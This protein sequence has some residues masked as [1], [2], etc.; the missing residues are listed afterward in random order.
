M[1]NVDEVLDYQYSDWDLGE[2]TIRTYLIQIA[3][4]CWID[5]EGFS[6]KRPFGNSGW[7]Y[8]IC[9]AL[10]T[11]GFINGE[12]DGDGGWFSVDRTAADSLIHACFDRLQNPT[13]SNTWEND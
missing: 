10:A 8:D 1:V 5:G 12:R 4:Q 9:N 7:K 6:G 11:G 3:R 2:C 13:A